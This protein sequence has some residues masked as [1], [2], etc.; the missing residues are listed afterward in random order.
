[1]A[2]AHL[3]GWRRVGIVCI[4]V[5]QQARMMETLVAPCLHDFQLLVERV[6]CMLA[7]MPPRLVPIGPIGNRIVRGLQRI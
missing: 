7:G 1:M 2:I 3:M 5:D 6:D 4:L